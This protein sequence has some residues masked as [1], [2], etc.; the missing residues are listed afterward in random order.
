MASGR[1]DCE[2]L[3]SED[4][5]KEEE[6]EEEVRETEILHAGFVVVMELE[7]D[8]EGRSHGHFIGIL[9]TSR[10]RCSTRMATDNGFSFLF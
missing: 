5:G 2:E 8:L 10:R 9:G 3:Q 1:Y 6:E 7:M 4:G